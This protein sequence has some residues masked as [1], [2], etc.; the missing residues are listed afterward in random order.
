MWATERCWVLIGKLGTAAGDWRVRRRRPVG[1]DAA[2]VEVDWAWALAREEQY[3]DVLGFWHTHPAGAG[4]APSE[5][6]LRTM[7]AW[8]NAF[9]KPLLCV[10]ADGDRRAAYVFLNGESEAQ[11]VEL[12]L[13]ARGVY[14]VRFV[15]PSL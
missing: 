3:G 1:G 7:R 2:S 9:G 15:E 12:E 11:P 5:R 4:V 6:D 14:G 10:I 13:K 8:C